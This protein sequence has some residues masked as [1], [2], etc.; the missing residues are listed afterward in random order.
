MVWASVTPG[1]RPWV[2][3]AVLA[4]ILFY[5]AL[6][7]VRKGISLAWNVSEKP[8]LVYWA[9]PS[10]L[11]EK[12]SPDLIDFKF[13][14]LHLRNGRQLEVHLPPTE[15]RELITWLKDRNPSV[16]LGPYDSL[17]SPKV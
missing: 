7:L 1:C 17:D 4:S 15:M 6:S 3:A 8:Q 16:R 9:Q 2:V 5:L 14:T 13:L 10:T 11:S 12:F